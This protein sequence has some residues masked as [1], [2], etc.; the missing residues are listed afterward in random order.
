V[1]VRLLLRV[2][3]RRRDV[4]RPRR[5]LEVAPR[6]AV[7]A[8]EYVSRSGPQ[9]V[10]RFVAVA[11]VEAN[12]GCELLGVGPTTGQRTRPRR[13]ARRNSPAEPLPSRVGVHDVG[14]ARL[15]AKVFEPLGARL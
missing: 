1:I 8:G 6:P 4:Q 10:G 7:G 2:Y 5:G 14:A 15:L 3:H 11:D 12:R 9:E 13:A